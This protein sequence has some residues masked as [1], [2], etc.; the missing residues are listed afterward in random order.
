MVVG[1]LHENRVVVSSLRIK[2]INFHLLQ[3]KRNRQKYRKIR[4]Y[5]YYKKKDLLE[6]NEK[7]YIGGFVLLRLR[8]IQI[9][10]T[11]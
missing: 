4:K 2:I 5:C 6:W 3:K 7:K 11:I 1:L 8:I 10:I 9:A